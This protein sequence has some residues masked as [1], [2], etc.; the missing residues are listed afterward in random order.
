[1]V[2]R[3]GSSNSSAPPRTL[4][5]PA[6]TQGQACRGSHQRCL[7][8]SLVGRTVRAC[9]GLQPR[10]FDGPCGATGPA[11]HDPNSGSG[12]PCTLAVFASGC[13]SP[14]QVQ[15]G[16]GS[17]SRLPVSA[18]PSIWTAASG[19]GA[20]NILSDRSAI[21][22]TGNASSPRIESATLLRLSCCPTKGGSCC[23]SGNTNSWM[24]WCARSSRPSKRGGLLSTRRIVVDHVPKLNSW[25]IG[26]DPIAGALAWEGCSVRSAPPLTRTA[27]HPPPAAE[28]QSARARPRTPPRPAR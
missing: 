19:T 11:E 4:I 13:N 20:K 26:P 16:G 8:A 24:S 18:S 15:V 5:E 10:V 7:S 27:A 21:A 22:S 28:P 12:G 9:H 3:S 25:R 1:M 23:A 6:A 17:T 14:F 2:W